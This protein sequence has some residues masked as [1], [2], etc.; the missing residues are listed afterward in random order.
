MRGAN[1]AE[2]MAKEVH[3]QRMMLSVVNGR[4]HP[5]TGTTGDGT[6]A[7]AAYPLS[8]YLLIPHLQQHICYHYHSQLNNQQPSSSLVPSLLLVPPPTN[9]NHH[10]HH[11]GD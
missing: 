3:Y 8:L 10:H 6:A 4:H 9:N 11:H 2:A 1:E 5:A 7:E